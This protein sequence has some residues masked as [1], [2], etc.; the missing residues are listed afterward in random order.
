MLAT[1]DDPFQL[2]IA[3]CICGKECKVIPSKNFRGSPLDYS[4]NIH[5][6]SS[7]MIDHFVC[8]ESFIFQD[9]GS[10]VSHDEPQ[11]SSLQYYLVVLTSLV[12]AICKAFW[13]KRKLPLP[14]GPPPDPVIGHLRHLLKANDE[15][16]CYQWHKQYGAVISM[17][18]VSHSDNLLN[19]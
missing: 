1:P 10:F 5:R 17:N 7:R 3:H 19:R 9:V 12:V 13:P 2:S 14:P 6:V 4:D 16:T 8:S 15:N 11:M 18:H